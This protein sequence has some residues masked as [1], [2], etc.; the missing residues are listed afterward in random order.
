[1][2]P[3]TK[4]NIKHQ[5][6]RRQ[7]DYTDIV[8]MRKL[9]RGRGW[10]FFGTRDRFPRYKR[11][12]G[13]YLVNSMKERAKKGNVRI[14]ELDPG[15]GEHLL[16]LLKE[17]G[18]EVTKTNPE[19]RYGSYELHTLG[20]SYMQKA[21]NPAKQHIGYYQT[22]NVKKL[23]KFD[24]IM[25]FAGP[26]SKSSY[27]KLL[28]KTIRLLKKGGELFTPAYNLPPYLPD[29]GNLKMAFKNKIKIIPSAMGSSY[30]IKKLV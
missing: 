3:K 23:G 2:G 9:E 18:I 7:L 4:S 5:K 27:T 26:V 6:Y 14:L 19:G 12:F 29:A 30:A 13:E 24:I 11:I 1:M 28:I 25:E 15:K 16:E 8:R 21:K 17:L 22:Y 20:I 10:L